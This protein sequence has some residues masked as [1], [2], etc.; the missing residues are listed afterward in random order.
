MPAE[1]LQP[2]LRVAMVHYQDAASGGGSLRVGETIANHVDS[3]RIAAELVFAYEGPGPV[4]ERAKVPCHFLGAKGPKDFPAWARARAL[5]GKL[6]PD[7]VHFQDAVVWLRAA[8]T[9]T[10][11]L[12]MVHVHGRYQRRT[13]GVVRGHPFEASELYH[14]FLQATDAQVCINNGAR[15]ALLGLGW[16]KPERSYVVYNAI[17]VSRFNRLPR[18][19]ARA[20]LGLPADAL[21][22]GMICRL[23]WEK[24][25]ADLLSV[26]ERLPERWH[27]VICG[28]GPEK[29]DLQREC[30]AR[31][32]A[33][34][35]HFLGSQDDV[36]PIYSALDAYALLSHYEPFGLVLA[37]AM[38]AGVPVFGIQSGGEFD[39]PEFPLVRGDTVDL[40]RFDR[41]G[42]YESPVPSHLLDRL[43]V[44]LSYYGAR[45]QAY[46]G[47]VTRARTWVETCFAAPIQARAMTRVFENVNARADSLQPSLAEYY[48]SRRMEAE[49][50]LS[51]PDDRKS[52][53][54]NA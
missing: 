40:L 21:L 20:Q 35:M 28:D 37:E 18:A 45:P 27:G 16:I 2:P 51:H 50:L 38:A 36:Q 5:F 6:Q 14:R 47:M 48:Q 10:P 13:R 46:E 26:I 43:A 22:L 39:E 23:V 30:E 41:A 7:I 15:N 17:D 54:A 24:G 11:Y 49:T 4:A 52:I 33:N 53:A 32:L 19:E 12:K 31:G 9:G 29:N 1:Q 3:R 34:R 42:D 44:K 8:L 25:C